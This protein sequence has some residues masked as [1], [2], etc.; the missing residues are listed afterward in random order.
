MGNKPELLIKGTIENEG[1]TILEVRFTGREEDG[2][3]LLCTAF[4]QNEGIYE[5]FH[6]AVHFWQFKKGLEQEEEEV[7]EN[8]PETQ[9]EKQP[10]KEEQKTEKSYTPIDLKNNTHE[11]RNKI[12]SFIDKTIDILDKK[13]KEE[14]AKMNRG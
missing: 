5:M 2:I 10:K 7:K 1:K 6:K 3:A 9:P 8:E 12:I 4:D 14:E 11:I 13:I